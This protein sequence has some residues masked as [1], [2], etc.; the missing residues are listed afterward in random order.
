M[1]TAP[2]ARPT[3][4]EIISCPKNTETSKFW[5]RSRQIAQLATVER[6]DFDAPQPRWAAAIA[7]SMERFGLAAVVLGRE[8]YATGGVDGDYYKLACV[9][10]SV[11]QGTAC[12]LQAV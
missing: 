1:T 12:G 11:P 6:L 7:M 3:W 8:I 10:R 9:E 2:L 4:A 5:G